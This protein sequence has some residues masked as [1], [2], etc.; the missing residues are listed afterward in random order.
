MEAVEYLRTAVADV[1]DHT[2]HDESKQV[3]GTELDGYQILY[4]TVSEID[5]CS[6]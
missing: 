1:V 5:W 2:D 4:V 6:F 3:C